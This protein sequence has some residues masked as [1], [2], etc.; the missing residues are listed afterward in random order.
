HR[1]IVAA[2]A[3]VWLR[4]GGGP[5]PDAKGSYPRQAPLRSAQGHGTATLVDSW[6]LDSHLYGSELLPRFERRSK[7]HGPDHV[8]PDRHGAYGLRPEPCGDA[9]TIGGFRRRVHADGGH[10]HQVH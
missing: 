7:R 3:V 8:D 1:K 9:V 10:S 4:I 5:F 2:F 6:S